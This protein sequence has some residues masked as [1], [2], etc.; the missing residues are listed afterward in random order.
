MSLEDRMRKFS[1]GRSAGQL[2]KGALRDQFQRQGYG[3]VTHIT[4]T[5]SWET[6]LEQYFRLCEAEGDQALYD[7]G[8]ERLQSVIDRYK[9][10][11]LSRQKG[12]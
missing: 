5:W 9:G 1:V 6:L 12:I 10:R 3:V 11:T 7:D 4:M 8:I 2:P